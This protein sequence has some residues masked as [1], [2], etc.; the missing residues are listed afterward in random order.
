MQ[1]NSYNCIGIQVKLQAWSI[2]LPFVVLL[3]PLT[4]GVG[5]SRQALD[6][7]SSDMMHSCFFKNRFATSTSVCGAG[8]ETVTISLGKYSIPSTSFDCLRL[9]SPTSSGDVRGEDISDIGENADS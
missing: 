6:F 1:N 5:L 7:T 4:L 8:L 3:Q 9:L 2:N